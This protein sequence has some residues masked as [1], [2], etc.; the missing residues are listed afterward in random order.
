VIFNEQLVPF[1]ALQPRT[2]KIPLGG[3]R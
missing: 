1:Y 2:D 3:P